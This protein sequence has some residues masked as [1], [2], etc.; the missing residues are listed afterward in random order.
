MGRRKGVGGW[1]TEGGLYYPSV[2]RQGRC[3]F[4]E[5]QKQPLCTCQAKTIIDSNLT[6]CAALLVFP[7]GTV[8]P[9]VDCHELQVQKN[10]ACESRSGYL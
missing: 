3:I 10:A 4:N 9:T 6:P 7:S 8:H 1:E 2:Q 5:A